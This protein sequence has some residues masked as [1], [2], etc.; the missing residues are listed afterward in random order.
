MPIF[1]VMQDIGNI[2]E[3]EMYRTFNMGIGMVL[4]VPAEQKQE[5]FSML[6]GKINVYEIGKSIKGKPKVSFV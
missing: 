3:G 6:K 4:I 5:I 1:N 2:D